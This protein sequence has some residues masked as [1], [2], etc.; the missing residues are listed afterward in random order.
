MA[1]IEHHPFLH[2]A[3]HLVQLEELDHPLELI[4]DVELVRVEH[5][6]Y[7]V[8]SLRKPPHDLFGVVIFPYGLHLR[9]QYDGVVHQRYV[10]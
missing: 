4:R 6:Y 1:E 2:E 8:G 5:D 7:D 9:V 3:I 10:V